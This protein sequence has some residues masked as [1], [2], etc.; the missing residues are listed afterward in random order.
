MQ[1]LA[2]AGENNGKS[3][4][5]SRYALRVCSVL[6]SASV[7][8]SFGVPGTC[9]CCCAPS[10][11]GVTGCPGCPVLTGTGSGGGCF[12]HVRACSGSRGSSSSLLLG[13]TSCDA[14]GSWLLGPD[15]IAAV[16]SSSAG[17]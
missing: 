8:M 9:C 11:R 6:R 3:A 10:C 15:T 14:A 13:V 4:H 7:A 5:L 12:G 2:F 1:S 16:G 17:A